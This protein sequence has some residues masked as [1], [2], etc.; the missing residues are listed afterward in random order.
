MEYR[1]LPLTGLT[2]A[3]ELGGWNTPN[4][5]TKYGV[6]LRT[7]VPFELPEEDLAFLKDYGV[8]MDID[9]RGSSELVSMPDT[10]KDESWLEYVH[11]PMFDKRPNVGGS[12]GD[13]AA[14]GGAGAARRTTEEG[15]SWGKTYVR[16][17]EDS[18][19][20][21]RTVLET[22]AR[23]D[24]VV[25]YHCTTGKDRTGIVS[26]MILGLCGVAEE[27]IMADYCVS[28][29]YLEW[30]YARLRKSMNLPEGGGEIEPFFKT[31][32][33]NMRMLLAH[34]KEQY[35]GVCGFLKHC[36]VTEECMETI[37]RRLVG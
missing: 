29:V 9:L 33:T 30:L 14:N 11:M 32:P 1:R 24:G 22:I 25:M 31:A 12:S 5:V 20:W 17:T 3:R 28:E 16:M 37:R 15:F 21:V 26:A 6:F 18:P 35:G 23:A 2:N 10:L 36:G 13:A 4:G 34:W 27:D 7:E 19:E 8:T